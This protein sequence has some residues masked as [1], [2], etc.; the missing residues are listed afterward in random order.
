MDRRD[1][2][3]SRL[4]QSD[5]KIMSTAFVEQSQDL[6]RVLGRQNTEGVIARKLRITTGTLQNIKRGRLKSIPVDLWARLNNAVAK[7]LRAEIGRLEAT[8]AVVD[9]S[10]RRLGYGEMAAMAAEIERMKRLLK[11][12]AK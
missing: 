10:A 6:L 2:Q 8:L 1:I 4:I 5:E 3:P 11:E 12:R 9:Q 7:E